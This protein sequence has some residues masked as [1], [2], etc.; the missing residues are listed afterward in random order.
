MK[1]TSLFG[2]VQLIQ[3]LIS[4]IRSKFI[5]VLIGSSGMGIVE[6]SNSILRIISRFPL[7]SQDSFKFYGNKKRI[8]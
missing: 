7:A 6:L 1:V 2:G 8:K 3:I 5:A 4:M